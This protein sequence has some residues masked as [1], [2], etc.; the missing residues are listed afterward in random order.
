MLVPETRRDSLL[1]IIYCS[2]V[3]EVG[4]E[5]IVLVL[6]SL[7]LVVQIE[8]KGPAEKPLSSSFFFLWPCSNLKLLPLPQIP[9]VTMGVRKAE[10]DGE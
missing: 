10:R 2:D 6:V 8:F 4:L 7:N 1:A 9:F 3:H 5:K